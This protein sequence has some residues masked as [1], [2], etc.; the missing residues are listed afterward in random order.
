MR[1]TPLR[2]RPLDTVCA[3][4]PGRV[5][6]HDTGKT[7]S[8]DAAH[9]AVIFHHVAIPFQGCT[10]SALSQHVPVPATCGKEGI[11][12]CNPARTHVPQSEIPSPGTDAQEQQSYAF[13]LKNMLVFAS[14]FTQ[15]SGMWYLVDFGEHQ[16]SIYLPAIRHVP[17]FRKT[18]GSK[19]CVQLSG[20]P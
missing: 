1:V 3:A 7:V 6:Q 19:T 13:F 12:A 11:C 8:R 10:P 20:L 17:I 2:Q 4:V 9:S 15:I 5:C 14:R 18:G 16:F